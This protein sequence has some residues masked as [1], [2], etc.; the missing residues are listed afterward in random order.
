[1]KEMGHSQYHCHTMNESEMEYSEGKK[2][3]LLSFLAVEDSPLPSQALLLLIVSDCA[4]R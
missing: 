3:D 2:A 4:R 1:M